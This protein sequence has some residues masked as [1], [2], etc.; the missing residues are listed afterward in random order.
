MATNVF[1]Y[2]INKLNK[3][4]EKILELERRN[5]KTKDLSKT[6]MVEKIVEIIV[7]E[8]SKCY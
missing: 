5:S 1:E 4:R 2:D 8:E 6:K 7:D 3:M